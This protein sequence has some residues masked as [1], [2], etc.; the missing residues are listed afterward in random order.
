L[1]PRRGE[2]MTIT[3][4]RPER[5]AAASPLPSPVPADGWLTT[6]DHKRLG[7]LFVAGGLAA[8]AAACVLA[9]LFHLPAFGDGVDVWTARGSR[10]ASANVTAALVIGLPALWLGLATY[11]VPLQ[12]GA[13]RLALP[14]LHALAL[15]A[16]AI[17]G[18]TTAVAYALNRPGGLNVGAP[19]PPDPGRPAGQAGTELLVGGLALV[20]L[21]TLLAAVSLLVTILTRRAPGMTL[22]RMPLF[23]WST[24]ATCAA[25]V[26]AAPVFLTGLAI[27]YLDRHYGGQFFGAGSRGALLV[28]QHHLWLLGRPEAFLLIAPALGA[29]S[30]VVATRARRPLAGFPLAR[31]AAVAVAL[32]SL[33]A[34]AAGPS[35][36]RSVLPPTATVPTAAIGL[37]GGLVVLAW[38]A[39]LRRGHPRPHP[40]L[41]F[42]A[43][44]VLL[45]GIA[46]VAAPIAAVVGVEGDEAVAFRNAQVTIVVF[47]APLLAVAG[48]VHHWAPKLWGRS[49][50]SGLGALQFL[51]L[52]GGAA[53]A[54]F[55]GYLTG[56]GAGA[57][58]APVA[59][60]GYALIALG[61]VS[62]AAGP[63][64]ARR[65]PDASD[66]RQEGLTLEWATPSPPPPH[67]FDS[68]P[69]VRSAHPLLDAPPSEGA[70]AR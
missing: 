23:A 40:T 10:L 53:V 69:E 47:G 11:V 31:A 30:D 50:P 35:A 19:L 5:T 38:L 6:G 54:A 68:L 56:L 41:L 17:G 22:G 13:T 18:A 57:S 44:F 45:L 48:A 3:E 2:D 33:L 55:P 61:L 14:R 26:L 60:A 43:G 9:A 20:T 25:L 12:I 66:E 8:A 36:L 52:F 1:G 62:F 63:L 51:L 65:G 46:A 24:L 27:L 58:L 37:P 59:I 32:M 34:W 67:N 16:F 15:W 21:A 7:I 42:A 39:T 49:L 64:L 4:A 29:L 70:P 28:W